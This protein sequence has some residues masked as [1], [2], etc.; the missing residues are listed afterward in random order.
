MENLSDI[1]TNMNANVF[2]K[3][4]IALEELKIYL[5]THY[6]TANFWLQQMKYVNIVRNFIRASRTG[7]WH[8]Y[9]IT[10][11]QMINLFDATGDR[12]YAKSA[13]LYLQIMQQLPES[14]SWL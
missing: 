11:G 6:K 13:H 3:L 9:F 7:D 4:E 1:N 2:Q 8:L 10:L 14:H 12:N 5:S